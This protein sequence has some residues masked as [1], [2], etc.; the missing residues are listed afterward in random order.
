[1]KTL[2]LVFATFLLDARHRRDSVQKKMI[3]LLVLPLGV[4][5]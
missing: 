3:N 1:M 2:K 4:A 5:A